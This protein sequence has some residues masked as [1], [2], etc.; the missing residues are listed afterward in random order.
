M[1]SMDIMV[2]GYDD[3][4]RI[5]SYQFCQSLNFSIFGFITGKRRPVSAEW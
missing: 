1:H 2:N 4:R 3:E 5:D